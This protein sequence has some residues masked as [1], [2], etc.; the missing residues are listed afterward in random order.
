MNII[1]GK[2][3]NHFAGIEYSKIQNYQFDHRKGLDETFNDLRLLED[4]YKEKITGLITNE[5]DDQ[6]IKKFP[7]GYVWVLLSR[8]YCRKEADAM[9]HCGNVGARPDD[10]IISLRRFNETLDGVDYYNACLT[11]ILQSDGF[12]GEMKGRANEKP[13]E[14]YHPYIV[15]LLKMDLI[16]GIR[17]GGYAPGNNFALA[18]LSEDQRDALLDEKPE[19]GG[20]ILRL[21]KLGDTP[22]LRKALLESFKELTQQRGRG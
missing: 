14:R 3:I 17:G 8:G 4:E 5:A 7:D 18:D 13:A 2:W 20:F 10:R 15:E 6:I 1:K 21:K 11:F 16:K 12:L 9:G 19:L 22:D